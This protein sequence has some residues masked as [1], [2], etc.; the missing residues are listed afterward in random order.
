MQAESNQFHGEGP[1]PAESKRR[2]ET[3]EEYLPLVRQIAAMLYGR[4]TRNDVEFEEYFQHGVVGLL[5]AMDRYDSARDASFETYATFRIRGAILNGLAHETERRA[6]NEFLRRLHNDR[7][8]SGEADGKP[9]EDG[10]KYLMNLAVR[11][12]LGYILERD[13]D[14]AISINQMRFDRAEFSALCR[15]VNGMVDKLPERERTVIREHYFKQLSFEQISKQIGVT[16]G[17]VSQL[18][19]SALEA[20]QSGLKYEEVSDSF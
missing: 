16:K 19:R 15:Q 12:A 11:L 5:E 1:A 10:F 2:H 20:I 9:S 3:A 4:R 6:H 17:R 13:R 14:D 18:H 8:E 7:L